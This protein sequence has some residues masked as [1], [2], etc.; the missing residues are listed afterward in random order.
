VSSSDRTWETEQLDA[1]PAVRDQVAASSE[2]QSWREELRSFELDGQR[3]YLPWGDV[4]MDEDQIVYH[5]ASSHGLLG[6]GGETGND[7]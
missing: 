6:Q 1:H 4:P 3:L 7:R 5:W 2:F